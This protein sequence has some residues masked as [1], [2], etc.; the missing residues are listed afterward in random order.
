MNKIVGGALV[1]FASAAA[2]LL[3]WTSGALDRWEYRTW[4][5]RASVMAR[6]A[7]ST[8]K[9]RLVLLDQ[10]SL[11]WGQRENGLSWPWPREVY[12]AIIEY[13]RR[14]GAKSVAFDVL[15]TEPSKYGVGD[16]RA[17]GSAVGGYKGFVGALFLADRTGSET[18]W[19]PGLPPFPLTIDGFDP[20]GPLSPGG[21]RVTA[22][23]ASFPVPE[24]GSQAAILADVQHDPDPD[25]V[26]R[27]VRLFRIFDGRAVPSLALASLLA[28]SPGA[29]VALRPGGMT[30]AGKAV[31][32]DRKGYAILR[33][34]GP[35]G[36]YP[37]FSAA[38][39]IQSELRLKA[40]EEPVIRD[41]DAFRDRHVIFGFSAPGLF[42]LRPAPIGGLFSG[43]EIQATALDNLLEGD[44]LAEVTTPVTAALTVLLAL[45]AAIPVLFSRSAGKSI[46]FFA[47]FLPLPAGLSLAAYAQGYWVPLVVVEVAVSLSLLGALTVNYATEGKQKRFIKNA[48][49]QYLSP[50]VIEQLIAHP[51][52]LKLG[53]E[54]RILSVFFS[55]LQGFTSI[56]EGLDPEELT[57]LLNDYLSAMT[58]IIHDEGGTLDKYVGDAIIA[59]WNAPLEQPDHAAR[60]ARSAIRCQARLSEL[61]P[62]FRERIGKDLAMRI[63]LNTGTAIVGNMGSHSRFDYTVLGD[64]VNLASRLE[65]VN[66]QFGTWVLAS[67]ALRN[68]AG[69][70]LA[71][72]EI[73]RVAVVG[74][75]EAIRVFEL[76]PKE[77]SAARADT[78]RAFAAGLDDFT[79]GRFSEAIGKFQPIAK[80]DPPAAAYLRKCRA[81]SENPPERWEGVWTATEK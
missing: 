47:A 28:A 64:A 61:R 40:G 57:A 32:L 27:R 46:L 8:G 13:L 66:K 75:R 15:F 38:A 34:R 37:A 19:P 79:A 59:F 21:D 31:P 11:D 63:G 56:A 69:D 42:D 14:A 43:A 51:E 55:D 76:F 20:P 45:L 50:K 6:P 60:A 18:V 10:N 1:A 58:D 3:L 7:P 44:F 54:R 73:S 25:G 53:G 74:R 62:A 68:A 67:E 81:L 80:I 39:V 17:L 2:A 70:A 78:H 5:W 29:G 16:D 4:D 48:F 65:G 26:Y 49:R 9:V 52:R 35:S 36:T 24:I 41:P 12:G 77:E 33:F 30:I 22:Q 23:R 71:A 72:R